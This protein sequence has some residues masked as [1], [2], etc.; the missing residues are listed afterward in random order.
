MTK[1]TGG[2]QRRELKKSLPVRRSSAEGKV[3][4]ALAKSAKL[5]EA[6]LMVV[7]ALMLADFRT[8]EELRAALHLGG[9]LWQTRTSAVM[10]IRKLG[11]QL[12]QLQVEVDPQTGTLP[13]SNLNEALGE[14][15][16]VLRKLGASWKERSQK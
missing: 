5:S 6:R 7:A 4:K 14:V 8:D 10:Q 2:V 1:K 12:E 13:L 9:Q 16:I 15:V 3:I 11:H